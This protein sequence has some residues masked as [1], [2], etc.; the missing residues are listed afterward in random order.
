LVEYVS[1][2][3]YDRYLGGS[4][5]IDEVLVDIEE[6]NP[7]LGREEGFADRQRL[8]VPCLPVE[9]RHGNFDK[10]ELGFDKAEATEEAERCLQC[11][12]R[13]TISEPVSPPI[14]ARAPGGEKV[15]V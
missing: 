9:E 12:L 10:V 13:F 6:A 4:G 7:Y 1:T 11:D 2:I 8:P 5:D 15:G 14:K 3:I